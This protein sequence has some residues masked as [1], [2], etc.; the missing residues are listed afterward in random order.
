MRS[1]RV[2]HYEVFSRNHGA[3]WIVVDQWD[4]PHSAEGVAGPFAT[5]DEALDYRDRLNE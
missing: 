2:K 4:D 5:E 3:Y 1:R